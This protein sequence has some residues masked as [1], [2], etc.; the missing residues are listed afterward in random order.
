M[1][2]LVKNQQPQTLE[3]VLANKGHVMNEGSLARFNQLWGNTSG[4]FEGIGGD[5]L[6]TQETCVWMNKEETE[7]FVCFAGEFAYSVWVS[8][9]FLTDLSAERIA[10][11]ETAKV[12]YQVK[13]I[14]SVEPSKA[15]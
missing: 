3:T 4:G 15:N 6:T 8:P 14:Y 2:Y 1:D 9:K 5:A 11:C 13:P 10:G 7:A 12:L